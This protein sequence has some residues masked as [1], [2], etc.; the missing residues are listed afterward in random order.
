[1][2]SFS[3]HLPKLTRNSPGEGNGHP[4]QYFYWENPVDRGACWVTVHGVTKSRTLLRDR[5]HTNTGI[6]WSSAL[7]LLG[8]TATTRPL[9]LGEGKNKTLIDVFQNMLSKKLVARNLLKKKASHGQMIFRKI[10]VLCTVSCLPLPPLYLQR[11]TIHFGRLKALRK[12][13]SKA[14]CFLPFTFHFPKYVWKNT[15]LCFFFFHKTW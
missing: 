5:T 15:I 10:C 14:I 12:S 9:S 8:K 2:L 3:L 4:L 6:T 11:F 1:M 7:V 13:C